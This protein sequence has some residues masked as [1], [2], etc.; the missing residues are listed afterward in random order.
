MEKIK[1]IINVI[2][3]WIISNGI[4]GALGI[5]LGIVLWALGHKIWAGVAFG[6][7]I[8]KNWD[9]AKNWFKAKVSSLK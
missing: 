4:E 7:F 8:Q 9:L 3:G 5:V 2:K 6:V 1:N